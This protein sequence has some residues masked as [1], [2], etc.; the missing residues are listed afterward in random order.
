[1]EADKILK[2]RKEHMIKNNEVSE[3]LNSYIENDE[4][5]CS[6]ENAI[7][8]ILCKFCLF[9]CVLPFCL[10]Y[11]VKDSKHGPNILLFSEQ[12]V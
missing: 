1:M 10:Q 12:N 11:V 2:K 6:S 5:P 9:N 8:S 7:V 3:P 4:K